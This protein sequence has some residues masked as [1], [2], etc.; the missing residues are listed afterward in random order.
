MDDN[1]QVMD[2][3]QN[4]SLHLT[5]A[6]VVE[7]NGRY[8]LVE[9]LIRGTEVIN[10]PAGHVEPG[11]SLINAVMRE[12]REET[13]WDFSTAAIVGIYL[14]AHPVSGERFLRIVFTGSVSNHDARQPLDEG[15]LRSLWLT[16]EELMQRE[17]QLRSPM[18]VRAIDDYLAGNRYPV[19]MFQQVDIDELTD[20]AQ[21][22]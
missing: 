8:L 4:K 21:V 14:W 13:A 15:I 17:L 22:I 9:E 16:R 19:S 20:K 10:Q 7:R 1:Q 5:V 2:R 11:E 3:H 6:A 12:T 18:V